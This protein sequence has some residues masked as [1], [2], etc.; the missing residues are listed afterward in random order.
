MILRKIHRDREKEEKAT[1]ERAMGFERR[2]RL[3]GAIK[4]SGNVLQRAALHA[5]RWRGERAAKL[6]R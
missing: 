4:L 2:D 6:S 5:A 3:V 1:T